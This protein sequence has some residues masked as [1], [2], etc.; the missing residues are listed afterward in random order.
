MSMNKNV[1]KSRFTREDNPLQRDSQMSSRSNLSRVSRDS[2][3]NRLTTSHLAK[4]KDG[5]PH[6]FLKRSSSSLTRLTKI[7]GLNSKKVNNFM[8]NNS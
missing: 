1:S 3:Q 2:V 8:G 6:Q 7:G 4:K 5:K